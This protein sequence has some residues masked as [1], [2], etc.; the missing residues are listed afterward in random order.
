VKAHTGQGPDSPSYL[1]VLSRPGSSQTNP[2]I[3]F[4]FYFIYLFDCLISKFIHQV[5]FIRQ[6]VVP[7][8]D[9]VSAVSS[10]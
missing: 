1:R 9:S 5:L 2:F 4:L 6:F 3:L 8:I 10:F 7:F